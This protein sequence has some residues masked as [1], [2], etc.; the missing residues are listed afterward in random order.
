MPFLPLFLV[1]SVKPGKRVVACTTVQ[2]GVAWADTTGCCY[3]RLIASFVVAPAAI[4]PSWIHLDLKKNICY[5]GS[6]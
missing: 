3:L 1:G 4:T 5:K 6:G 2:I